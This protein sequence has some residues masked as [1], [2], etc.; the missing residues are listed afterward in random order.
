MKAEALLKKGL[1]VARKSAA[2]IAHELHR[3][4]IP[5]HEKSDTET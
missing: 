2:W 3:T 5:K 1:A 4:L